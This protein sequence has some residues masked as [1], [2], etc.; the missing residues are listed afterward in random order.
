MQGRLNFI[1]LICHVLSP[2]EKLWPIPKY[3]LKTTANQTCKQPFLT[4]M[5]QYPSPNLRNFPSPMNYFF[6][7]WFGQSQLP[8]Q[9]CQG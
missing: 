8:W 2:Y 9:A 7:G 6:E 5:Q 1:D 3:A 4:M